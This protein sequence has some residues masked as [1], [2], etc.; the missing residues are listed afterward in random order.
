MD[1]HDGHPFFMRKS[2][3]TIFQRIKIP[4]WPPLRRGFLDGRIQAPGL[5]Q[6][7]SL[8][9]P[10][11]PPKPYKLMLNVMTPY[12]YDTSRLPFMSL[13]MSRAMAKPMP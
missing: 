12:L 6:R 9:R 10:P 11:F 4:D 5:P 1:A 2:F 13:A 8:S 3:L 7:R